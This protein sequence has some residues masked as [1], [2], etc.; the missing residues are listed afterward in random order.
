MIEQNILGGVLHDEEYARR[1][2]PFLA[3][4][5]FRDD[6]Q[7]IVLELI[8]DYIAKY[9]KTPSIEAL[10]IDLTNK[11]GLSQKAFESAK[12]TL[13]GVSKPDVDVEWLADQTEQFCKD[14]AIY[15]AIRDSMAILDD[16]DGT[17]SRGNIPKLLQDALGVSFDT[18]VGHDFLDDADARF[19]FYHRKEERVPFDLEYFNKITKGGLPRKTLNIILAGTGVGKSLAMCHFAATNL[20]HGKNV[21]YIT[22]EMAEE[23]ISQR[24]DANLLDVSVD[25]LEDLPKDAF[26]KKIERLRAKT[27]GRLIVKEFPTASAHAGHFR[28]LLNELRLKKKFTPDLIYIDYLNI[29]S[30]SRLKMGA[31][32][33]SYT[34][35]KSIAEELRGLAVEFNVPIISA[36]QTTRGGY[37]NSDVGLTDTSESFGLPATADLMFALINTEELEALGQLMVKQLKNRYNDLA[38]HKRF[39]V[40]VDR[41]KFRLFDVEQSA[42][43]DLMQDTTY[44]SSSRKP[45]KPLNKFG[46]R[47]RESGNPTYL[48]KSNK[49]RNTEFDMS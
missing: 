7:R 46:D 33:N 4:N 29:C 14:R 16:K 12:E 21:L 22:M 6:G 34:F 39:T 38:Y 23:K 19:E 9:N 11:D 48:G 18:S 45:D 8:Q 17:M 44:Q 3:L 26:D 49:K 28:H 41:S 31:S 35:I 1:V 40:G 36:T 37:D 15:N 43:D 24:I 27:A 30:S 42:Q 32:V 2:L 5:Y 13:E 20:M 10:A 25:E 47:E